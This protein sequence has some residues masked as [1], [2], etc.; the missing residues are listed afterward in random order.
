V[1]WRRNADRL[2]AGQLQKL[3]EAWAESYTLSDDRGYAYHAGLHGAPPPI[4]CPHGGELFLPWHRAYLYFF[5][6]SL[7]ELRPTVTLPWWDWSTG[8]LP[9]P[10]RDPDPANPLAA[11]PIPPA[12]R[13]ADGR[14]RTFRTGP[15]SLPTAADIAD[16]LS[17]DDF[18]DF[19][20]AVE[21]L[22]NWVHGSIGGT[23]GSVPRAA[24]DPIFWAHHAFVDRLW[25]LWQ[26]R[27]SSVNL[28]PSL[29]NQALAPFP[30]TVQQ[31]LSVTSLGYDYARSSVSIEFAATGGPA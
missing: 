13:G 3:R 7:R 14:T 31:T 16:A 26:L 4:E 2:T 28:P 1:R 23:M 20:G 25:R 30:M 9:A 5:E 24:Y 6:M 18:L 8:A 29:L 19:S 22:H 10:Y 21:T 12:A 17:R 15:Q 27:H 11:G